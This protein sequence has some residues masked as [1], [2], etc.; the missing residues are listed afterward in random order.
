MT[1]FQYYIRIYWTYL[2]PFHSFMLISCFPL[3]IKSFSSH[4]TYTYKDSKTEYFFFFLKN[5][6]NC[7]VW[8]HCTQYL[9]KYRTI[10]HEGPPQQLQLCGDQRLMNS[11]A[12]TVVF[13][14]S[15]SFCTWIV[16]LARRSRTL[17]ARSGDLYS[18]ASNRW[19]YSTRKEPFPK[20]GRASVIRKA[21]GNG[22]FSV[23]CSRSVLG[24]S[25]QWRCGIRW[26]IL[27]GWVLLVLGRCVAAN[28]QNWKRL[29]ILSE[30]GHLVRG[31]M[32]RGDTDG[33]KE[34]QKK[35]PSP[36]HSA[37]SPNFYFSLKRKK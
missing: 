24:C 3:T 22:T 15:L 34:H 21:A 1:L 16:A 18:I 7:S 9:A 5:S 37:P 33:G 29:R 23:G 4:S 12:N 6:E 20:N 17:P 2:S 26:Q 31:S 27:A 11:C 32:L 8:I 14:F 36:T 13:S 10:Y 28:G 19:M 35:Y 25:V 30:R